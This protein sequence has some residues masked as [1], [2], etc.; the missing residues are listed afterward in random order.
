MRKKIFIVL[1]LIA[2][3]AL[4]SGGY[5]LAKSDQTQ[6]VAKVNNTQAV[7]AQV[8]T[9]QAGTQ[10]YYSDL[11]KQCLNKMSNNKADIQSWH[12]SSEHQKLHQE[13]IKNYPDMQTMHKQMMSQYSYM[14]ANHNAH[15]GIQS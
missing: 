15:H 9:N 14:Q 7:A 4:G 13:M 1:A 3:I 2:I 8:N 12:N 10:K 6:S 5:V 11:Y